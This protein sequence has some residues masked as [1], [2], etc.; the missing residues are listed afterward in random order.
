MK[1]LNEIET[2]EDKAKREAECKA[3]GRFLDK[4]IIHMIVSVTGFTL[5][6]TIMNAFNLTI[7]TEVIVGYFAFWGAEGGISGIIQIKKNKNK[8]KQTDYE[9][10][11]DQTDST[12]TMNRTEETT[13]EEP[14]QPKGAERKE[15]DCK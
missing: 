15:E 1:N 13:Y 12:K 2:A 14:E 3:N 10:Y 5:I 8:K 9:I 7:Q 11:N 6:W 4:V